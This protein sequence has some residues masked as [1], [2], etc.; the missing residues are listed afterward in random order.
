MTE[1]QKSKIAQCAGELSTNKANK[2]TWPIICD[3]TGE[4]VDQ[5]NTIELFW[6]EYKII[7]NFSVI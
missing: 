3:I 2:M 1:D 7:Q 4:N 6:Q 5:Q